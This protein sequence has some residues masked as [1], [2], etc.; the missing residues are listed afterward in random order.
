MLFVFASSIPAILW[1]GALTP[2]LSTKP[3]T[4]MLP[5]PTYS[6]W[7]GFTAYVTDNATYT[8]NTAQ[9]TCTWLPHFNLQ[10]SMLQA[11]RD[12]SYQSDVNGGLLPQSKLDRTGFTYTTRSY[13]MSAS[14]GLKDSA[15]EGRAFGVPVTRYT[16]SEI[17]LFLSAS[18]SYNKSWKIFLYAF[19]VLDDWSLHVFNAVGYP[20]NDAST[21]H[22]AAALSPDDVLA[23]AA[24]SNGVQFK[25]TTYH[26]ALAS[27][28]ATGKYRRLDQIQCQILFEPKR[29]S[30]VV[31]ITW[32]TI[33]VTPKE[34]VEAPPHAWNIL[35]VFSA[36][37]ILWLGSSTPRYGSPL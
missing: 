11:A 22:A 17:G 36:K 26:M 25:Y 12:A 33:A 27:G 9:G 8:L 13:G 23:M 16:C 35:I 14:V 18:C 31:N 7:T 1:T 30:I 20:P 3:T 32:K 4:H 24:G 10:R 29:F 6:N 19:P 37:W 28:N 15:D 21:M 2:V 34:T 5:I